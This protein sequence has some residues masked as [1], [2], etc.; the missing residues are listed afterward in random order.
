LWATLR[1]PYMFQGPE[2]GFIINDVAGMTLSFMAR[3]V[4]WRV[5]LEA[6]SFPAAA[7]GRLALQLDDVVFGPHAF[8]LEVADG[9][10]KVEASSGAPDVRRSEERRVGK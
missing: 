4:D 7:R 3:G 8:D 10:A 6:R 9:G 5:A 1:E 2:H